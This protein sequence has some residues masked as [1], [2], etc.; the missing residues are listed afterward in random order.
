MKR[1]LRRLLRLPSPSRRYLSAAEILQVEGWASA[2][3]RTALGAVKRRVAQS[4]SAFVDFMTDLV[5]GG[6]YAT[7]QET[8]RIVARA[9]AE[10]AALIGAELCW[11]GRHDLDDDLGEACPICGA[12]R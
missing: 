7:D 10:G 1:L 4:D 5:P 8:R 12:A 3:D 11:A 6:R 9:E 2:Y